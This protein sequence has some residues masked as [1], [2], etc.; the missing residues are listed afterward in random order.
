MFTIIQDANSLYGFVMVLKS[1]QMAIFKKLVKY[2][3]ISG[4]RANPF[5][6]S[7]K[8]PK[9]SVGQKMFMIVLNPK[10]D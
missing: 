5:A 1:H 6:K 8:C 9:I 3:I 4:M 2:H 10:C 7:S